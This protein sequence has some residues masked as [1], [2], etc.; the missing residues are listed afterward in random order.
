MPGTYDYSSK[1]TVNMYTIDELKKELSKEIIKRT[2]KMKDGIMEDMKPIDELNALAV[3]SSD[4]AATAMYMTLA[5]EL[6]GKYASVCARCMALSRAAPTISG[7][8]AK[9]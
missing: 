3:T 2:F 1:L 8:F 5:A 4:P 6:N 9:L 7:I